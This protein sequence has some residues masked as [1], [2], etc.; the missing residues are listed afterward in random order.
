MGWQARKFRNALLNKVDKVT[1][2]SAYFMANAF[3]NF[4][5]ALKDKSTVI[6]NGINLSEIQ[7]GS[8]STLKLK[9]KFSLLFPGGAKWAKGGDL[10]I[11]ALA[12]VRQEI[13]DIHLYIAL[14]VPQNHLLRKMVTNLG[15]EQNVTFAGFLPKQEYRK[16]LNSVDILVMPSR[17]EAFGVAYLEAMALGKPIIAGNTGGIPEVVKDRRNGTLV[18]P[19]PRQIAKAILYLCQHEDVRKEMSQNN[20]QDVVGFDWGPISDQYIKLYREI[21]KA[22]R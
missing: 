17:E 11:A 21:I 13:P 14:N 19:E 7:D 8:K 10:L 12:K 18:E 22:D 3:E 4:G 5:A 1:H 6:Y 15:L 9:G 20:L 2:V 16:L